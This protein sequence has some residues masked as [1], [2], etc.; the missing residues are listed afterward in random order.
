MTKATKIIVMICLTF[1]Q[2]MKPRMQLLQE[3]LGYDL[4]GYGHNGDKPKRRQVKT[5]TPKRR[6]AKRRHAS[7]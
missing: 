5:A 3:R 2:Y 7:M 1:A 6:Q 4:T